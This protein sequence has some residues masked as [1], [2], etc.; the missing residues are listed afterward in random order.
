M[1]KFKNLQILFSLFL[2]ICFFVTPAFAGTPD[3]TGT[4]ADSITSF[5][6]GLMKNGLAV[7]VIRS[8]PTTALG[9]AINTN[10]DGT[11]V[12]LGFGG[13]L[14]LGFTH[15]ISSGAMVFE[16]TINPYPDEKA[17]IEMSADG[18]NWVN[19]GTITET[20]T[21]NQ[22]AAITC[23]KY[24]RITDVSDPSIFSDATADG[25]DVEGV[26]AIGDA[27]QPALSPTASVT[28]SVN[29]SPTVSPTQTPSNS[30]NP[31]PTSGPSSCTSSG[32]TTIANITAANRVSPTSIFVSWGPNAGLNNFIVEY[33]FQNGNWQ[34]STKVTGFSTTI[35][36]LPANQAIWIH[37]AA[38]D[39]CAIGSFGAAVL[40]GGTAATNTP[41]FPNTGNPC[42][43]VSNPLVPCFPNT[44]NLSP[45]L[46]NTGIDPINKNI[47]WNIQT[48][49][50]YLFSLF[51]K[52]L[53]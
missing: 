39:N 34:F 13:N 40:V 1:N 14:V 17:K 23:A 43:K 47:L 30:S 41:G 52:T 4:W 3:T 51:L 50:Q 6:Q 9:V 33:G 28:P 26:H 20:A 11:F 7:P 2:S 12:A 37:V 46:P 42:P 31:A 22:P 18:I 25:Y 49:I 27:C 10:V 35:N 15:G 44:G 8:D 5:H 29:P 16:A 36:A 19:A 21:V 48:D 45:L 53:I 24:V 38:T 32:I